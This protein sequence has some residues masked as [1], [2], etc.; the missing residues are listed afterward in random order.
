MLEWIGN[1]PLGEVGP[2][3]MGE[4]GGGEGGGEVEGVEG[5]GRD[6]GAHGKKVVLS[7]GDL[8]CVFSF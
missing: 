7:Q 6:G 2:D 4:G 3:A 8:R 1:M 5:E